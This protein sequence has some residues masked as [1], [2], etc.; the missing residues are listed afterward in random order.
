MTS[1]RLV[2][3][4]S[5]VIN[6][7]DVT[8]AYPAKDADGDGMVKVH[9]RGDPDPLILRGKDAKAFMAYFDRIVT[10]GPQSMESQ[11]DA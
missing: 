11:D 6:L 2:K 4:G 3:F 9:L 7:A 10:E 8:C 1:T 5:T